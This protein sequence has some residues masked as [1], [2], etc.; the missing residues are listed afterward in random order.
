MIKKLIEYKK[1]KDLKEK[2]NKVKPYELPNIEWFKKD[3]EKEIYDLIPKSLGWSMKV[4][5]KTESGKTT[6]AWAVL[7]FL[8]DYIDNIENIYLLSPIFNQIGWDRIR[9]NIKHINDINVVPSNNSIIVCDDMQVQLKGNKVITEIT[10]NKRHRNLGVIQCEQYTQITDSV[11]KMNA[12]YFTL[13]GTFTL[14]DCQYFVEKFL[15]S[16]LKYYLK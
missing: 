8:I 9:K 4:I 14:S 12:D 5:G 13:L 7:E 16:M 15:S 2:I 1:E 3:K 11:Q 10:L 6:F